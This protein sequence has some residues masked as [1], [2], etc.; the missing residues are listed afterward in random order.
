MPS[1]VKTPIGTPTS[2]RES[3]ELPAPRRLCFL[4]DDADQGIMRRFYDTK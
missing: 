2:Q 4:L 3:N 1:F